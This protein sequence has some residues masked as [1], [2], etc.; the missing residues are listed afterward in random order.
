RHRPP[1]G[2]E[3]RSRSAADA[4]DQVLAVVGDNRMDLVA[5]A[6]EETLIGPDT[7]TGGAAHNRV[8][9]LGRDVP[10]RLP[11]GDVLPLFMAGHGLSL[12]VVDEHRPAP[13]GY[14]PAP[15]GAAMVAPDP[16]RSTTSAPDLEVGWLTPE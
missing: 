11:G 13:A 15:E 16:V 8:K 10:A 7:G 14:G 5:V 4:H 2:L 6:F 1:L 3:D 9:R 12:V